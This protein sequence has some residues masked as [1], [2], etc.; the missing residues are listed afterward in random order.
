[1][2]DPQR[3]DPKHCEP[4]GRT[5][6]RN[7][8]RSWSLCSEV[9]RRARSAPIRML[10]DVDQ[11]RNAP[12]LSAP[13]ETNTFPPMNNEQH[14]DAAERGAVPNTASESADSSLPQQNW[15][16]MPP[17]FFFERPDESTGEQFKFCCREVCRVSKL[18]LLAIVCCPMLGIY[19]GC[20]LYYCP[21]D[22]QLHRSCRRS[23]GLIFSC[24]SHAIG[25]AYVSI[26]L[27]Y[28]SIRLAGA[29]FSGFIARCW[30]KH[31]EGDGAN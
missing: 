2:S 9:R 21:T 19:L 29:R 7:R 25:R 14:P 11:R 18:C 10:H 31:D 20:A 15:H 8:S 17:S 12:L 24:I 22:V 6:C 4:F 13:A 1:V 30:R 23:C 3:S 28:V 5:C 27:A 26:R 16:D